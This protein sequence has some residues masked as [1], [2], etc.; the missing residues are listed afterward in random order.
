ML[1]LYRCKI[2]SVNTAVIVGKKNIKGGKDL[3]NFNF[4]KKLKGS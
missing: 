3:L 1:F 2:Y 4:I